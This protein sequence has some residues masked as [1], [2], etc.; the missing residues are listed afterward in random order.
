[1]FVFLSE[2]LPDF[3]HQRVGQTACVCV[4]VFRCVCVWLAANVGE[5]NIPA[6][7]LLLGKGK[8]MECVSSSERA[9]VRVCAVRMAMIDGL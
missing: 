8:S 9:R 1:M 5:L 3:T 6:A 4:C 7:A 2:D